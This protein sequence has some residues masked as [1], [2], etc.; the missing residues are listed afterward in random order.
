ML[1][2]DALLH[3][4]EF[5]ADEDTYIEEWITLVHVCRRWRNVVFQSPRRLNL[6]LICT[7][8]TPLRVTLDIWPPLPLI[9]HDTD[10]IYSSRADN[11]I[12]ALEHNDRICQI[13]LFGP[14]YSR[15]EHVTGSAVM[16][17]PFPKLTHLKFGTV[18]DNG[19][20]LPDS[21]L[22][23]SAPRLR[24]L[25]LFRI[26]FLALPNLLSSTTQLVELNLHN[27]PRSGYI[28]PEAMATSLS[29]LTSLEFLSLNHS[30]YT[31]PI[32][33]SRHS[34]LLT[35]SILPMLT[36]ILFGGVSGYLEEILARIDAPRLNKMHI[37][38]F[39]IIFDT[40]QLFQFISRRPTLMVPEKCHIAFHFGIFVNFPS[41]I[42][43]PGALSVKISCLTLDRQLPSLE[44]LFTSSLPTVPTLENLY[45]LQ[46][47]DLYWQQRW[48]DNVENALWLR[49]LHPFTAVKSLYLCNKFVPRIVPALEDLVG[50]RTTEVL[51]M[52]EN[53]FLEGLQPSGP[54]HE[55]IETF[56]AARRLTGRPVA[57]SHW[58]IK[59]SERTSSD[60]Y[61]L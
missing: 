35:R 17:K 38:F 5:Y 46:V 58:E 51:P 4:F 49:V 36:T 22:G 27:I 14:S 24:S 52:L 20:M 41:Q 8:K 18:N 53:I 56:V 42:S 40:P 31:I 19:P 6:R 57:V 43:D 29:A 1:D 32:L 11:I 59:D 16:Q 9:I 21:F 45:I 2:D 26:P 7:P 25:V 34:P 47:E 30:E 39:N 33:E 54:L 61:D 13:Q 23:G 3:I 10:P 60:I 15:M 12:A 37:T 44:R 28:P 55:G 48:L 50:A